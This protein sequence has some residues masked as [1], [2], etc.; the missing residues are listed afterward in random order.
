[1]PSPSNPGLRGYLIPIGGA[2]DKISDRAVLRRFAELCGGQDGHIVV[3]PTASVL[4]DTGARY[5]EVFRAVGA[6]QVT[7]MP[8]LARADGERVDWLAQLDEATGVFLT[9][10]NQLRLS[11]I[12]G[13]TAIAQKIRRLHARGV[14][15]AGTSAGAA[16]QSEHMIAFGESGAT[17]RAGKVSLAPGLGLINRIIV[18]QHFGQRDRLGRLLTA[19]SY[20]PFVIGCGLDED[21]AAFIGPDDVMEVVG[22]GAITVVDVSSL[23][24]SSMAEA[25]EGQPVELFGV[26]LHFLARG[27]RFDLVKRRP[28][29]AARP[30]K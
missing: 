2:E 7:V 16:F 21:T 5:L 19:L 6:G 22:S 9:G 15:V 10:G 23:E 18:D 12:L 25:E 1:M 27:S 28:L 17:P 4:P 29:P 11:T 26:Q 30:P 8:A 24:H 13:G 3:I 14:H 20:N